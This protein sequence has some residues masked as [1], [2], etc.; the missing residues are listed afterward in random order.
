MAQNECQQMVKTEFYQ[1]LR[2]Q[3]SKVYDSM[4]DLQRA[5]EFLTSLDGTTATAMT[6]SAGTQTDIASLRTAIDEF[7]DFYDGSA[8]TQTKVLKTQINKMRHI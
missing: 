4:A 5:S 6:I 2:T 7:L 8:T 1:K 3:I